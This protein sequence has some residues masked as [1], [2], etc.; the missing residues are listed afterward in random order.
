MS[1]AAVM[2]RETV[3]HPP[4]A[5]MTDHWIDLSGYAAPAVVSDTAGEANAEPPT[6]PRVSVYCGSP[7]GIARCQRRLA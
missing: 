3:F 5:G 1:E 4:L 2:S 7:T 6:H